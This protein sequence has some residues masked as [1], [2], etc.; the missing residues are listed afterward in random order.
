MIYGVVPIKS[1]TSAKTRL[2]AKLGE[3]QRAC[4][5]QVSTERV[6][7]AVAACE[8]IDHRIAVVDDVEAAALAR[9]FGF[10]VLVRPDLWGQSAVVDAGFDVARAHGATS[11]VTVS[12][13]CPLVRPDDLEKLVEGGPGLVMVSDREGKGTNALRIAPAVN[14]RLHFGPDSLSRH[15]R[16]AAEAG[17]KVRVLDL[18]RLRAD[19]DTPDDLDYLEKVGPEGRAVLIEAGQLHRDRAKEAREGYPT[20]V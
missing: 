2:G 11:T 9:V 17:M 19:L 4:L 8:R 10:E 12:A 16:E 3:S 20:G 13:D 18:P 14:F 15:K 7:R 1:F 6:L 5:A